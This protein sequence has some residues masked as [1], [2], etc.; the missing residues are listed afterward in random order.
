MMSA[1]HLIG[2]YFTLTLESLPKGPCNEDLVP[3]PWN[4]WEVFSR[5]GSS[6]KKLQHRG[7]ASPP[8]LLPGTMRQTA[9]STIH[10]CCVGLSPHEPK[11]NGLSWHLESVRQKQAFLVWW[12][13]S[14]IYH[15]STKSRWIDSLQEVITKQSCMCSS[16]MCGR[17]QWGRENARELWAC[18]LLIS[19]L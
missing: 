8:S 14:G 18:V 6:R 7:H 15:R 1:Y 10:P 5:G 3:I 12:F 19:H 2:W 13:V 17:L 16:H 9:S 4:Y 11:S